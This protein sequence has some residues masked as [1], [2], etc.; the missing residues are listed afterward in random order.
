MSLVEANL[1]DRQG[2]L[3]RC[4]SV[5]RHGLAIGRSHGY[6]FGPLPYSCGDLMPRLMAHA[7]EHGIEPVLCQHIVRSYALVAPPG[8]GARWTWSL[9]ILI[10]GRFEIERAQDGAPPSRKESRKPLELL[11]LTLALGGSVAVDRVA[12]ALWPDV[13]GDLARK[14]F[15]NAL[16]RLRKLLG[17]DHHLVLRSGT[18][19]VN[20]GSCW[21]DLAALE[22]LYARA[23]AT[24]DDAAELAAIAQQMLVLHA[25]PLLPG[26][27]GLPD[28]AAARE[29][30]RARFVRELSDI[31][32][33]LE[34]AGQTEMAIDVY[35]RA[36]EQDPLAEALYR[37]LMS[38]LAALGRRAEA[39]EVYRRCRA[40]L[41]IL[42]GARPSTATEVLAAGLRDA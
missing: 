26:E 16:H 9:K 24:P 14:S 13:E 6:D 25:G 36:I 28:I 22:Q 34:R 23:A 4:L 5:L 12:A 8:A 15:D 2:D 42:L 40:Q 20:S 31:G 10:L 29:Q 1:A 7:L 35:R 38:G 21:T 32:M 30:L 3:E 39:Y 17:G 27:D 19:S 18:L 41:S 33:R 37:R 11:K